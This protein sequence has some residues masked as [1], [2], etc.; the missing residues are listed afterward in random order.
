V[1]FSPPAEGNKDI[2]QIQED[3]PQEQIDNTNNP[4]DK[5]AALTR[6]INDYNLRYNMDCRLSDF[7]RYYQDMQKR[8]KDQPYP[9]KDVPHTKKIDI[10][11][12]VDMLLTGFD[13]KYLS[14]LYVDK[15]LKY[16][17]LIQ[18][19]SRTNRTL[20]DTKPYGTILDF[21][22]QKEAVEQAIALFSGESIEQSR[23][24]WLVEAAPKVIQQLKSAVASLKT[25][26]QSHDLSYAPEEVDNLKGDK[27]RSQFINAFKPIQKLKTQLDQYTDLTLEQ[28][29]EIDQLIAPHQLQGFRGAYLEVAHRLKSKQGNKKGKTPDEIEQL[30]FELVLFAS[31]VID[32]DYIIGLIA[33]MTQQP[34]EEMRLQRDQLIALLAADAKFIDERED[35]EAYIHSLPTNKALD[36]KTIRD[37]YAQFKAQKKERELAAIAAQYGLAAE[38]LNTFVD[39]ILRRHIFDSEQLSE[40]MA[41]LNL[42]WKQRMKKETE[43]VKA[44]TPLLNQFS[45]GHEISGLE[46]YEQE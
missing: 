31:A 8:I 38:A 41:A 9:N 5:K 4:E 6:I 2:K 29:T 23:K 26:M 11:I 39:T 7:D 20:N 19:F 1:F 10:C 17:G 44:L 13:S 35:I 14:T 28:K 27:A 46:V 15:N 24:I 32:Y 22:Q 43:L 33:R 25:F 34:P 42:N 45:Q 36:E 21:R 16:H 3:L 37:G 40:L 30:D 12:V 18:A